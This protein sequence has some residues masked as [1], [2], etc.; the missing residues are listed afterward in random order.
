MRPNRPNVL[1]G[2]PKVR[3]KSQIGLGRPFPLFLAI[4]NLI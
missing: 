2:A 4:L 1:K 3:I